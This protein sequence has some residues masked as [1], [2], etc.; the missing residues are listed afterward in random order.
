MFPY[1]QKYTKKFLKG[2]IYLKK[3]NFTLKCFRLS[4]KEEK[5]I[6]KYL[7]INFKKNNYMYFLYWTK[8]IDKKFLTKY[9]PQKRLLIH[10]LS[11]IPILKQIF[12]LSKEKYDL[13]N[14]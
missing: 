5:L 8:I 4:Q 11:V 9:Y 12:I 7:L 10:S 2:L 1:S 14:Q 6:K 13:N 3:N